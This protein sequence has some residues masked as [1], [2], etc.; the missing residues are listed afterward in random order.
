M[1]GDIVDDILVT[2]SN[3]RIIEKI[4]YHLRPEFALKDLGD[5]NYFLGLKVTSSV[6]GLHL[7]QTK[8]I[9]DLLKKAQMLHCKRC[10]TP[11]SSIEKL[12]KDTCIDFENPSPCRSLIGSLQYV[13][14]IFFKKNDFKIFELGNDN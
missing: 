11:M 2:G 13:T 1:G 10:Q 12:V 7:S 8:Y 3:L 9:R 14:L 6:E 5:F 4:I